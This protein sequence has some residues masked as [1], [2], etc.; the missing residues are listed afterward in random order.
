MIE[1]SS[2]AFIDGKIDIVGNPGFP[3]GIIRLLI[4]RKDAEETAMAP[5]QG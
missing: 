1:S 3:S 4:N 2:K 5:A